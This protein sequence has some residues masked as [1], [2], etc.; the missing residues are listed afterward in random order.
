M[1]AVAWLLADAAAGATYST[2]LEAADALMYEV[3]A[4]G[5][6]SFEHVSRCSDDGAGVGHR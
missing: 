5:K 6:G 3:K 4:K 2:I 1:A